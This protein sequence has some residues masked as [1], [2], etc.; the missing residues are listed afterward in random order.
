VSAIQERRKQAQR[1]GPELS[2]PSRMNDER[3]ILPVLQQTALFFDFFAIFSSFF[4]V[5]LP[6]MQA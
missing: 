2:L 1:K 6:A 5:T 4:G 3:R